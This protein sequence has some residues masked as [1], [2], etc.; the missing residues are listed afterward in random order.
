MPPADGSLARAEM[1]VLALLSE[2]PA[3]GWALSR[4]VEP[5]SEIGE[6]WSGDRQRVY[7]ALRKLAE[8]GLIEAALTEPGEGAHRT[9]FR[10]TSVGRETVDGWLFEPVSS[11]R[12]A[13]STFILK[14]AFI[15]RSRRDPMPLLNAQRATVVATM[16]K[17]SRRLAQSSGYQAHVALR[18]ETAR[19]LLTVID[20]LSNATAERTSAPA[21]RSRGRRLHAARASG[22]P[23][24]DFSRASLGGVDETATII[25]R[26]GDTRRGIHVA[27]AHVD[28]PIVEAIVDAGQEA[29]AADQ[30]S[31]HG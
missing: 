15:Q 14:L 3:H 27:T 8:L 21:K 28:D 10:P 17:L 25:L 5:G 29:G 31:S 23:A 24:S 22:E 2:R 9:L 1:T 16:E 6:I 4:E 13:Q 30:R 20:R 11:L 19:A 26:F 18:L 12:E 7:R